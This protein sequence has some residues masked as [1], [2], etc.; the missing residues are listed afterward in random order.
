M[1]EL[2]KITPFNYLVTLASSSKYKVQ[3]QKKKSEK[4]K[5]MQDL[6]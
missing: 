1:D 6:V 3:Q 5:F 4:M 2:A